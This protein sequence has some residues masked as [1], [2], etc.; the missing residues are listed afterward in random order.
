[1][2]DT[3]GQEGQEHSTEVTVE[4]TA[5]TMGWK[6][7]EEYTGDP[8]K[9]VGAEAF[10][11]RAPLF[12]KIEQQS[13]LI[14][15]LE[16]DAQQTREVLKQIKEHN[17]KLSEASYKRALETLKEQRKVALSESDYAAAEEIRDQIDELRSNPPKPEIKLPETVPVPEPSKVFTDWVDANPWYNTNKRMR[18]FADFVGMKHIQ[19]GKLPDQKAVLEAT[20]EAVKETFPAAFETAQKRGSPVESPSNG[21]RGNGGQTYRPSEKEREIAKK[22]VSKGLF[23]SEAEYYKQLQTINS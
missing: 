22:F 2:S 6:P 12:D 19:E 14:K 21:N 5:R 18:E 16:R 20:L 15:R 17:E 11:S 3:E 9:W 7:R 10:V 8:G 4:D 23:K 1:M 13:G